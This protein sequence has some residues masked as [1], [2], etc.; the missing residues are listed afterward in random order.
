M[1]AQQNETLH[2]RTQE[3]TYTQTRTYTHTHNYKTQTAE[4]CQSVEIFGTH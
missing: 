2:K 3:R 4:E 1:K